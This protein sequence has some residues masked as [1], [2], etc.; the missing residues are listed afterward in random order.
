MTRKVMLVNVDC[1]WNLAIRRMRTYY[2]AQGCEVD[3]RDLGYGFYPHSKSCVIDAA[4][5]ELVA[6]SN[7]FETNAY[8]VEVVNCENVVYGGV[9]SRDGT[10]ML[11]PEIEACEPWYGPEEDTAHGFI[12]RGCIRN[13]YFCKVPKHEGALRPYRSV[14]EVVGGFKKAVFM[15]NNILAWGGAEDAMDWL[16][17]HRISC[18]FNQGLD[19]RLVT[20]SNLERLAALNYR[21]EY[22]FALDDARMIPFVEKRLGLVKRYIPKP[23]KL[24]FFVYVGPKMAP[25]ETVRRVEFLKEHECLPYVMRDIAVYRAGN[26]LSN[27]Y[28]D[29]AAWCNQP[30]LFKKMEFGEFLDKRHPRNQRRGGCR[31]RSGTAT[32]S[33]ARRAG[34]RRRGCLKTSTGMA[35]AANA[36]SDEEKED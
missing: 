31:S 14:E 17:E 30:G 34:A 33:D 21:G 12:T 2:E 6:V 26:D 36:S 25:E 28:T 32:R 1:R 11:P 13:C 22:A 24:K 10:R 16:A 7:I 27:F 20:E 18:E 4:G 19:I 23:W 3:M 9:G 15:D 35:F 29:L 8:R 5:Y